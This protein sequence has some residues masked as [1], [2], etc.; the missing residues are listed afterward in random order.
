MGI[1]GCLQTRPEA[2]RGWV[3]LLEPGAPVIPSSYFLPPSPK[4]I[5]C[6]YSA[7]ILGCHSGSINGS[8]GEGMTGPGARQA[9]SWVARGGAGKGPGAGGLVR[10]PSRGWDKKNSPHDICMVLDNFKK[11]IDTL[12]H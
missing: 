2:P 8:L 10:Q 3:A 9:D 11:E 12:V 5:R 1:G 7:T 4:K 6:G